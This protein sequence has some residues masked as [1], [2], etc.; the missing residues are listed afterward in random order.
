MPRLRLLNLVS[1][2]LPVYIGQTW[3]PYATKFKERY[4]SCKTNSGQQK[5][6]DH[7]TFCKK[8]HLCIPEEGIMTILSKIAKERHF[9]V[10]ERFYFRKALSLDTKYWFYGGQ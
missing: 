9:D 3:R 5:F 10:V 1:K 6:A 4:N 2:G 7:I 8:Y